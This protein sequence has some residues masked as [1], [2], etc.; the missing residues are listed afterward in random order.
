MRRRE[1][2]VM[3]YSSTHITHYSIFSRTSSLSQRVMPSCFL[4]LQRFFL[5][6]DNV[7]FRVNDTRLYHEFDKPF[8]IR[9]YSNRELSYDDVKSVKHINM[10]YYFASYLL[11]FFRNL[12]RAREFHTIQMWGKICQFSLIKIMWPTS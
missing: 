6:I 7:M 12:S 2:G 5:R 1:R 9:E 10:L 4:V 3:Y 8:L 11:F